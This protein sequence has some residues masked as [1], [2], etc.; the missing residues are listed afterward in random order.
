MYL[1]TILETLDVLYLGKYF[2]SRKIEWFIDLLT[3]L[4]IHA[5]VFVK[6]ELSYALLV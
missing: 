4:K 6:V 5:D 2:V 1:M 3:V